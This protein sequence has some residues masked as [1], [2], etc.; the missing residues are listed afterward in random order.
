MCEYEYEYE[1]EFTCSSFARWP[2]PPVLQTS[3]KEPVYVAKACVVSSVVL[4]YRLCVGQNRSPGSSGHREDMQSPI[5]PTQLTDVAQHVFK[6][7]DRN[8]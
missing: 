1:Y 2:G 4:G 6:Y 5:S 7:A 3:K 8:G